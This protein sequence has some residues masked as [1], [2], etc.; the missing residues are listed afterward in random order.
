MKP[1]YFRVRSYYQDGVWTGADH[2]YIAMLSSD[3]IEAFR[4]GYPEHRNCIITAEEF[5][6]EKNE[7]L[8]RVFREAGCVHFWDVE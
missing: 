5:D 3:A 8:F 6:R 4:K 2:I 1:R 7:D